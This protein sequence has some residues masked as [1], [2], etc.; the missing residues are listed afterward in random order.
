MRRDLAVLD[1]GN[2]EIDAGD[3]VA[4]GVDSRQRGRASFIH[5]NTAVAELERLSGIANDRVGDEGLADGLEQ[6]IS[7]ER[8]T[9]VRAHQPAAGVETS[10][11][12]L[13][14][15]DVAVHAD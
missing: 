9:G 4:A 6:L 13:D 12:E 14:L 2:R 5:E 10:V 15:G 3:T 7:R 1:R 8:E 11:F